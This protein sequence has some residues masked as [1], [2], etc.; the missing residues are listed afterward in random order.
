MMSSSLES[1][2]EKFQTALAEHERR[3]LLEILSAELSDITLGELG[4]LLTSELGVHLKSVA[5]TELFSAVSERSARLPRLVHTDVSPSPPS[6]GDPSPSAAP[7]EPSK[8]SKPGKPRTP[9]DPVT[10]SAKTITDDVRRALEAS[11]Q[12]MSPKELRAAT[13]HPDTKVRLAVRFFLQ[14][15]V[16]KR[17][18]AGRGTCYVLV[19][20]ASGG[21]P[22]V[23]PAN[24]SGVVRRRPTQAA[25]P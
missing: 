2:R 12:P 8:P 7:S 3:V 5:A 24:P 22:A 20:R 19:S 6:M 17:S 4:E 18:G 15:G 13:G 14:Q 25:R 23:S 10:A 21:S 1:F 16:V 11:A 9:R